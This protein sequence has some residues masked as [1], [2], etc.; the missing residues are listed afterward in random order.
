MKFNKYIFK[1]MWMDTQPGKIQGRSI[2]FLGYIL[3]KSLWERVNITYTLCVNQSFSWLFLSELC[4]EVRVCLVDNVSFLHI[5]KNMLSKL[6]I[7]V[8]ALSNSFSM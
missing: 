4:E 2:F 3:I 5:K 7:P 6:A 1:I 8:N